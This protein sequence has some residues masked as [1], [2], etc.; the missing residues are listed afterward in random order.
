M[1]QNHCISR[2]DFDENTNRD[3]KS[4]VD[5]NSRH[6]PGI[7]WV[8]WS[9]IVDTREGSLEDGSDHVSGE[10]IGGESGESELEIEQPVEPNEDHEDPPL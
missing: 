4:L 7:F 10:Q 2:H 8:H 1:S 9:E 6:K 5:S 3:E